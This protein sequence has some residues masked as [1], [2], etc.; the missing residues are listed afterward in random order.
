MHRSS[1][2]VLTLTASCAASTAQ[3][4]RLE[5]PPPAAAPADL[6][7]QA[8]TFRGAGNLE[9]YAQRWRPRAGD[10]R[11]VLVIH[12]GLA[13]HSARY[14][15]F[16][17]RL[18]RV[19]Y[20]VYALDM[21][22]H[23]RSA[24]PRVD[25]SAIDE[26][27][28]DLDR[29]LAEVRTRE[30]GRPL[31]VLGHSLGGLV[32]SL[33]AIERQPTVAGVILSGPGIA[34]D[35]PGF[36]AGA[37]RFV[38]RLAPGAPL[39]DTP[40][41]DF[42]SDPAVIADMRRDPLIHQQKGPARSS[43][44]A[45]DGVARVWAAVERLRVPVLAVHGTADK[46]TAPIGSRDLIA[47]CGSPDRTLR[48]YDGLAHDLLHE[49]NGGAERVA[50]DIQA[51]LDAHT[52]GPAVTFTSSSPRTLRGDRKPMSL[53]VELAARGERSDDETGASADL[54]LRL[55]IGRAT[56]LN[57]GYFGGLDLRGGY[58][59][60]GFYEAVVHPLGFAVRTLGGTS[61]SVTGGFGIGGLRGATETQ[62]PV[63]ASLELPVGPLHAF[64]RG[65]ASW[66]L[67][68]DGDDGDLDETSA[69]VG[70]RFGGDRR[71]WA[72]V[73]AGA[74]PFIAVSYR[75]LDGAE[76]FG[77]SIGGQIWGSN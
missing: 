66:Y 8:F 44:A 27:L 32:T 47:R 13:D 37:V 72:T 23:A 14:A 62:L 10:V 20:A 31:F 70:L 35:L 43:R 53:A 30:P 46:I 69:T 17:E 74:G 16:A 40:F 76:I 29:L 4:L 34:F 56:P 25:I 39:L 12:H 67:G 75:N 64:A 2:V 38:A 68:V 21:R 73:A 19:G 48:L 71:Y 61:L 58:F 6:D 63:E 59:D 55:G 77:V 50:T 49:P 26:L 1:L 33:Y 11:G 45:V 5:A 57:L 52:G 24:G 3:G 36:G 22:G 60:G 28:D 9:L 15:G 41:A 54:R 7:H 18:A 65:S 51:W 42:S